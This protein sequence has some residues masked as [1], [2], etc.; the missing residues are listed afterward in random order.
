MWS[1]RWLVFL[2]FVLA[3]TGCDHATKLMA[4][5]TLPEGEKLSVISGVLSLEQ[6]RNTDSA[7]SLLSVVIPVT[8][9]LA[10]LKTTATLGALFIAGLAWSRFGRAN[11]TERLAL[12][13][14]LGG[15]AGNAID[16]WRWGYVIDFIHV[17]YWPIFNVA[18]I[19]LSLGAGLLLLSA[20]QVSRGMP[21]RAQAS[22]R[23]SRRIE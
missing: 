5:S 1:L 4:A 10:I 8:P 7:F 2:A 9:R 13:C 19:A 22:S 18:D 11:G 20:W 14:L 23:D 6:A 17:E 3:I 12:A 16:R 21:A 15:A